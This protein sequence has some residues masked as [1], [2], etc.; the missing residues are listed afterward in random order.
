MLQYRY[1]SQ[2]VSTV[3]YRKKLSAEDTLLLLMDEI[4]TA[5]EELQEEQDEAGGP[6][7]KY[8]DGAKN[9][10]VTCLEY[11]KYWEKAEEN[12]LD[13]DIEETFPV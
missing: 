1:Y 9:A 11:L 10:Y 6:K 8:V 2:K 3:I 4:T 13:F 7:D 5:L 12:G